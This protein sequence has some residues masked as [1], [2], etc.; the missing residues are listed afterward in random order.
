MSRINSALLCLVAVMALPQAAAA[1]DIGNG[2]KLAK[3]WCAA[4]HVVASDQVHGNTQVAPFS[5]IAKTPS[6]DAGKIAFYLLLPHPKMP[7]I[8]LS[9]NEA[10]DLAAYIATQGR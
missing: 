4:C 5:A 3:R 8:D 10:A 7:D 1:V 9:R 2:E 6:L